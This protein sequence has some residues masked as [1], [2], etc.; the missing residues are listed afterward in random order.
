MGKLTGIQ[1]VRRGGIELKSHL[2]FVLGQSFDRKTGKPVGSQREEPINI[3]ENPIFKGCKTILD[4]KSR[5]EAFWNN[6]NE[7]SKDIVFVQSIRT[8]TD[9]ENMRV[10]EL[11]IKRKLLRQLNKKQRRKK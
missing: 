8:L 11:S 5:Y 2:F 6:L 1:C 9:Y 3:K 7:K 4:I 10:R